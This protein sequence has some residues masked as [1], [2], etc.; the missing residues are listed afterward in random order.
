MFTKKKLKHLFHFIAV[1]Q[2]AALSTNMQL[3]SHPRLEMIAEP[4]YGV[5]L[6]YRSDFESNDNRLGVLKN[7]TK[8]SSYQGPAIRVS[9]FVF[10]YSN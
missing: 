4:Y 7:R 3:N 5:K 2:S 6:R 10:D 1:S 8:N 9:R